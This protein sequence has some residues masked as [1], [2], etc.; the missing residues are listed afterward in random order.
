[1]MFGDGRYHAKPG[2]QAAGRGSGRIMPVPAYVPAKR[3]AMPRRAAASD[4]LPAV[5]ERLHKTYPKPRVE[6]DFASPVQLLVASILAAR[7][8]DTRVNQITPALFARFPD[9]PAFATAK[10]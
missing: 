8:K 10:L 9:A 3:I 5:V 2:P 1:M 4:R 7:C 6:L